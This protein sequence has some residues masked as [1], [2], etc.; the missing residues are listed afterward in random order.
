MKRIAI[1]LLS[2]AVILRASSAFADERQDDK[3]ARATFSTAKETSAIQSVV[4]HLAGAAFVNGRTRAID[5]RL[6]DQRCST[7]P[8]PEDALPLRVKIEALDG[9]VNGVTIEADIPEGEH[10]AEDVRVTITDV[11]RELDARLQAVPRSPVMQ[12][13]PTKV[14]TR[15]YS[16]ALAQFGKASV[17]LGSVMLGAGLMVGVGALLVSAT[18]NFGCQVDNLFSTS[19]ATCASSPR[20]GL[21]AAG[22]VMANGLAFLVTGLVSVEVGGRMVHRVSAYV[23]PTGGG[24]RMTF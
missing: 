5:M 10:A 3:F 12:A 14:E 8:Q 24:L 23:T 21:I 9:G 2:T 7:Q 19:N 22:V 11:A 13:K 16:P 6:D 20:D 15:M 1:A 17:V 18:Q 4:C